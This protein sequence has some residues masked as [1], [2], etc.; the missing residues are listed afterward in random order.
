MEN[1]RV[2]VYRLNKANDAYHTKALSLYGQQ[3]G[4]KTG[5]HHHH[6]FL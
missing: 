3:I 1:K 4:T 2:V 5:G 6:P